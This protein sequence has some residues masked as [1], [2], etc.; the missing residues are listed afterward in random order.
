MSAIQRQPTAP[1]GHQRR[2]VERGSADEPLLGD[3]VRHWRLRRGY[4]QEELAHRAGVHVNVVRK[5]EQSGPVA[6]PAGVRLE[7]LYRLARALGVQTARLFARRGVEPADQDPGQLALLPIRVA[8]TPPVPPPMGP[9]ARPG[10][11]AADLSVL[12][13][14]LERG[15]RFYH[16]DRYEAVALLLPDMINA[17]QLAVV[18]HSEGSCRDESLRLRAGVLLLAGWFL[19]QVRASDLAY[20]AIKDA[21]ADATAAGG[22]LAVAAGIAGE[23]WLFIRQGR[24]LD[25]KRTAAAAADRMEPR[26]SAASP[27]ELSAWGWLLLFAWAA[28]IRN[29]QEDEAR[30]FLRFATAAAGGVGEETVRYAHYWITFGPRTVAMKQ[31]EHQVVIG[32]WR[33]ALRFAATIPS[34]RSRSDTHQRH[35]LD[36]AQAHAGLG[37]VTDAMNVL[38]GL[39]A[40]APTWLRHQQMGREIARTV[41]ASRSRSLT[42]EMRALA[43]FYRIDD[44]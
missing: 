32:K 15:V 44:G 8:L 31:V 38:A 26:M 5:L 6:G 4:S 10:P 16:E 42:A 9:T 43:D 3:N 1:G 30:E 14:E 20:Q 22:R 27:A 18:H 33:Q 19:T 36:V 17:A 24:L 40:T 21:I 34:G 28:A 7:T 35:L 37:Q 12:R 13:G 41:L 39:R 25:A 2:V 29:N 11:P 23:C